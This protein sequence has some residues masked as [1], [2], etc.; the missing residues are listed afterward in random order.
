MPTPKWEEIHRKM[1][2]KVEKSKKGQLSVHAK[3]LLDSVRSW[4]C[5]TNSWKPNIN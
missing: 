3:K 5:F 4:G 2:Q 1:L